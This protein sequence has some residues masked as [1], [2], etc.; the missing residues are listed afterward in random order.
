VIRPAI[1]GRLAS[2]GRSLGA[3]QALLPRTPIGASAAQRDHAAAVRRGAA[4]RRQAAHFARRG[5][6]H[7]ASGEP[8]SGTPDYN[9]N[10]RVQRFNGD[11]FMYPLS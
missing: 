2:F 1:F 8:S 9:R 7:R 10:T 3:F 6:V 5:T 4:L 11:L